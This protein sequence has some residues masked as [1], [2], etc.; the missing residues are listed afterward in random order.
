MTTKISQVIEEFTKPWGKEEL[1]EKNGNFMVKRLTMHKGHC[2]SIQYH[3]I[4]RETV[5]VLSGILKIYLG[6]DK[7]SMEEL[8]L[9]SGDSITIKPF[10]VHRM[11]S[12]EDSVYL[13]ASTPELD[14][15]IR[16]ED[17]Y[18]RT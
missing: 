9:K 1:L 10:E 18:N 16:L 11:E 5:Y 8:I 12:I 13:E 7:D 3:E 4:K 2:C 17:K 15:V 14:D 6:P